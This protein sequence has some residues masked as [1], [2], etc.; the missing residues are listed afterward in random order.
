MSLRVLIAISVPWFGLSMLADGLAA[1]LL[2]YLL[3]TTVGPDAQAT[4]LGLTT[5]IGYALGMAIQPLAGAFSDALG[6]RRPFLLGGLAVALLGLGAMSAALSLGALG[7]ILGYLIAVSGG[8]I[9]QAGQQALIPDRVPTVLRGRAAGLKGLMDIGGAF[10]AFAVLA[11]VL[12]AGQP[13]LAA[14]MLGAGLALSVLPGVATAAASSPRQTRTGRALA[15]SALWRGLP[16]RHIL[17]RLLVSRFCVLLGVY[18]V[19]RFLVLFMGQRLGLDP[20]ATAAQ[21]GIVLAALALL[22]ALVSV[23]AGWAADRLG[24]RPLMVGGAVGVAVGIG[25]LPLATVSAH[26]ML[27]G[28]PLAVGTAAFGSGSWALATDLV[29]PE[30]AARYMGIANYATAGAAGAAGLLGPII[31]AG[32]AMAVGFGYTLLL[33]LA[34]TAAVAGGL[35][36]LRLPD[37]DHEGM[38]DAPQT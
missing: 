21:A 36:A 18:A 31:D 29:P 34:A 11:A 2:P 17:I 5:L 16:D 1:L 38:T 25:L 24:R 19:G 20:E 8:N 23:P 22:T 37:A 12:A 10:L 14:A 6:A 9:A 33:L 35:V 26:V 30:E 28:I 27:F 3:L 4:V 7:A 13:I 32:E 15:P